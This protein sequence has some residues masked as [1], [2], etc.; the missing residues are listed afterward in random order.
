VGGYGEQGR[1]LGGRRDSLDRFANDLELTDYRVLP[2]RRGDELAVANCDVALDLPDGVEHMLQVERV[3]VHSGTASERTRSR[4]YGEG[5]G[6]A[7]D[8]ARESSP[9]GQKHSLE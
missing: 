3:A 4:R 8:P 1:W 2:V 6:E 7:D 9:G 5:D